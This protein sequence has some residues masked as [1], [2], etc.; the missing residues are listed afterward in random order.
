[1]NSYCSLKLFK[2]KKSLFYTML[3]S[4]Y[5]FLSNCCQNVFEL[6]SSLCRI[7]VL[8][9]FFSSQF[10]KLLL[11]C[12]R[13]L[14]EM[15]SNLSRIIQF[16][17]ILCQIFELLPNLSRNVIESSK[18]LSNCCIILQFRKKYGWLYTQLNRYNNGIRTC[19]NLIKL[20]S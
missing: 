5:P 3:L 6:L 17:S 19:K 11:K 13:N 8:S 9:W 7:I 14:I 16:L 2:L 18:F 12:S 4:G 10:V 20:L 1:M 15:L